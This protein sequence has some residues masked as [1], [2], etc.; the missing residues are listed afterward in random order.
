LADIHGAAP[1]HYAAQLTAPT[2]LTST[3]SSPDATAKGQRVLDK[4]LSLQENVDCRDGDQRTPLLWAASA[5]NSL[6]SNRIS[7]HSRCQTACAILNCWILL[8]SQLLSQSS[9]K[10][11]VML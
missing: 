8:P 5:G 4:L 2:A 9:T 10:L 7:L 3:P 1:L 11:A 6:C